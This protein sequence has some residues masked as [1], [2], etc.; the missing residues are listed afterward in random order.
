MRRRVTLLVLLRSRCRC[1]NSL[2]SWDE[3]VLDMLVK[4]KPA[5]SI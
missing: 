3:Q 1:S 5:A 2:S 4:S